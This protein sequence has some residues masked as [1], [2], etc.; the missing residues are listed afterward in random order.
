MHILG[1]WETRCRNLWHNEAAQMWSPRCGGIQRLP[2]EAQ[3]AQQQSHLQVGNTVKKSLDS[4][5]FFLVFK[6]DICFYDS[7]LVAHMLYSLPMIQDRKLHP[8]HE[9]GGRWESHPTGLQRVG[10]SHPPHF[11]E[12]PQWYRWH[13]DQLRSTWY[14]PS[15]LGS[16]V[17]RSLS[18][19]VR[20]CDIGF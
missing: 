14:V 20:I 13:H 11:Q 18:F 10:L 2:Q 17:A 19:S 6:Q 15:W 3:V 12:A 16:T 1:D 7:C 5:F 8:R 4:F 9:E